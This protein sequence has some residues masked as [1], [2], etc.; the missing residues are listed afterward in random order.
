MIFLGREKDHA[1]TFGTA[2]YLGALALS[3]GFIATPLQNDVIDALGPEATPE[4]RIDAAGST[5]S[6][7]GPVILLGTDYFGGTG[8]K[9]TAAWRN[10]KLVFVGHEGRAF[11]WLPKTRVKR[12]APRT[13]LDKAIEATF[14]KPAQFS[15]DTFY[16]LGLHE[17]R[18]ME[19]IVEHVAS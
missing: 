9:E 5:L 19:D 10:G 16:A 1:S 8:T 6:L 7:S 14:G 3:H 11:S 4:E 18:Q 13:G 17:W 15:P 12:C 2:P